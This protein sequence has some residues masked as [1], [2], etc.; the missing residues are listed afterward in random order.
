ML[1][2]DP[3]AATSA[4][5]NTYQQRAAYKS[6]IDHLRAGRSRSF[7][8][9]KAQLTDYALFPYLEYHELQS[10]LS[11]AKTDEI[12]NFR[13]A[14]PDLPVARIMYWRWLKRLGQRREWRRLLDNYE[15]AGDPELRCY[16]LRALY[17]T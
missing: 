9:A 5:R 8:T 17:G 10:R 15:T 16:R 14:H 4:D 3:W 11:T 12:V 2:A 7:R 13:D 6:A 1:C